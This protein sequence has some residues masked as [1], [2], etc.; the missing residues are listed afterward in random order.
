MHLDLQRADLGPDS[1]V[2]GMPAQILQIRIFG[3]PFEISLAAF[4]R[5]LEG[6]N[7]LFLLSGKAITAG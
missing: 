7:C 3:E 5:F 2:S 1:A 4:E 6:Q